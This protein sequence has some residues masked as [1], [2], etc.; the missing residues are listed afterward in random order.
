MKKY[1]VIIIGGGSAG[2]MAGIEAS[3]KGASVL[4]LEKNEKLGKKLFLTGKGRCNLTNADFDVESFIKKINN[5]K[6]LKPALYNFGVKDVMDFFEKKKVYL[7]TE[8]GNR[9]FPKSDKSSDVIRALV[10]TLE[11]RKVEVRLE[12][13]VGAVIVEGKRIKKI[14]LANEKEEELEA[15]K[16]IITTGGKSYPLTG[17]TGD[18]YDW[19]E[20]MGH[21]IIETRPGLV[22][23]IVKEEWIKELEGLSLKN[24]EIGL[25]SKEKKIASKFGEAIFTSNGL[26][27]PIILDLSKKIGEHLG[28]LRIDFKPALSFDEL[29]KRI[30]KDFKEFDNK[31]FKNSLNSLLPQ[32]LIS[33]IISLSKIDPEKKVNSITKE[34]RKILLHLLKEFKLQAKELESFSRAVVTIGGVDLKEVEAKTMQS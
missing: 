21:K 34:E 7:K 25:Y 17:S 6:F 22:P 9:V 33:I 28:E 30:Q 10:K 19:L 16:Y 3:R 32:R 18:A 11:E 12:T 13:E 20:K 15:D 26:S 29:D 14:I 8:R 2:M 23:I 5:G 27:G 24:V 31:K 4:L 1:D